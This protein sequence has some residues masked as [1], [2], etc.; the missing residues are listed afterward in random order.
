VPLE[1]IERVLNE[2]IDK[3]KQGDIRQEE[4]DRAVTNS[5]ASVVRGLN[6]NMGLALN[7]AQAHAQLGS[8]QDAFSYLE[9][10]EQVTLEDLQ[11]VANEYLVETSRTVG[12]VR[13]AMAGGAE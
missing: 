9:E 12:M 2:E 3:A 6:S 11:R 8:W 5:R 10:L 4:L 13:N 1:D 7:L